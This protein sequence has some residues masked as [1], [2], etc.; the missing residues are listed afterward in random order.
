MGLLTDRDAFAQTLAA[1]CNEA[2]Y[3]LFRLSAT[4]ANA[5]LFEEE[6]GE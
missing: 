5:V 3:Q 2:G 4:G 6:E 1:P